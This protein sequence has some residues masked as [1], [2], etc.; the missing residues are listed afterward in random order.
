MTYK[1]ENENG[2]LRIIIDFRGCE[3]PRVA[4]VLR[5]L[6]CDYKRSFSMIRFER[7]PVYGDRWYTEVYI[8][9]DDVVRVRRLLGA[10][11]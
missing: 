1:T 3:K 7:D 2:M 4:D 11:S 8:R 6:L 5:T 9:K 10:E